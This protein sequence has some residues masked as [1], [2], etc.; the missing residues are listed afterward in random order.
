MKGKLVIALLML[1]HSIL[2]AGED[3]PGSKDHPAITRYPGSY[4]FHYSQKKFDEYYLLLGPL[5]SQ[6]D[7]KNAR[8]KKLEGKVTQIAYKCPKGRSNLEVFK[9]YEEALV[10][11]GY[12]IL[13]KGKGNDIRGVYNF[14]E[15][16][17]HEYIGGWDD[18]EIRPWFY[19]SAVSGE[20]D[21][22]VSL[23]VIGSYDGPRAILSVIEPKEMERGLIT[24]KDIKERIK[25]KGHVSIYGIYFD[26]GKADI[27]PESEPV[28]KEIAKFLKEN[29][30]IKVYVVGHTDNVGS[31]EYN[32]ELSRKRAEAVVKRLVEKYGIKKNRL[33]AFGVGPLCPVASNKKEDGRAKNRRVEIVEQ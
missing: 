7:I 31:L 21:I 1:I 10:R 12:K 25:E 6:R 5:K 16:M 32:M 11:A 15:K 29:P 24:A 19:L 8:M 3:V 28:L 13:F 30:D 2:R 20:E 23:F 14:L 9:N 22:Y 26:F 4:I 17:N 33:K 18:P 27:K